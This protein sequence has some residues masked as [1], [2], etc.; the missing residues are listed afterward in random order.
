MSSEDDNENDHPAKH[1]PK[2]N[3]EVGYSKPPIEHRFKPG[4]NANPKGRKKGSRSRKFII[5]DVL[6]EPISVREGNEVKSMSKLE[7]VLKKTLS[8]ALSGDKKA[9]L[10]IIAMAQKEGFLTPEEEEAVDNLSE[11]DLDI[12]DD[13]RRRLGGA[14]S[15]PPG[16][17]AAK[18][19]GGS[20]IASQPTT[21][22][23][24]IESPS[25]STTSQPDD[26]SARTVLKPYKLTKP[27]D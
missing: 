4:N 3:Y 20:A 7:A 12:M 16:E 19:L 2:G 21:G 13:A 24:K 10:T 6:L 27:V 11:T 18:S 26:S 9:A 25:L 23:P 17:T 5:A 15:E 22:F 14:R 8:Q 1:G